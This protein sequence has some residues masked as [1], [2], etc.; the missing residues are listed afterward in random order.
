[1]GSFC[2]VN[3]LERS[4]RFADTMCPCNG[5]CPLGA[6]EWETRGKEAP[7]YLGGA[8]GRC[9]SSQA[10][11]YPSSSDAFFRSPLH[12]LASQLPTVTVRNDL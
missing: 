7:G 3:I 5:K 11:L 4:W 12:G 6:E 1:M 8:G 9:Y 10:K 2:T